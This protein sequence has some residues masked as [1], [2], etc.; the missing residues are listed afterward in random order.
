V[1]DEIERF[2][3]ANVRP[4]GVNPAPPE[5]HAGYAA[6]LALPFLLLSDPTREVSRRFA[7]LRRDGRSIERTVYLIGR[8]GLVRFARRGAPGAGEILAALTGP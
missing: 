5:D 8:D 6:R 2:R 7:A 4:I 1:R 3:A